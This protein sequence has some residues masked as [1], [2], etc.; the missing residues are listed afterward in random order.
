MNGVLNQVISLSLITH[1]MMMQLDYP[2]STMI[3]FSKVFEFVT[4][5]L[6]PTDQIY[7]EIFKWVNIPF[8]K[9]AEVVGYP[10]HFLIENGGSITIF[11][12]L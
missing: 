11:I 5:D 6:I 1:L 4:F 12:I 3:F 7:V 9:M 10:S 2:Q 8:S